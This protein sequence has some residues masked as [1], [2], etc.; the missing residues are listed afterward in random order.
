MSA[1]IRVAPLPTSLVTLWG[2]DRKTTIDADATYEAAS[3]YIAAEYPAAWT[4]SPAKTGPTTSVAVSTAVK[5]EL[6]GSRS[7]FATACGRVASLA[8]RKKAVAQDTTKRSPKA[9]RI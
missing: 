8:G 1:R 3:T 7:A 6:A 2:T 5:N 9:K 4:S